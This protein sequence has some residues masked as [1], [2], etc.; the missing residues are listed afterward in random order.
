MKI[1][2][3]N[4]GS[5]SIKFKLYEKQVPVASGLV[6]KIGEHSSKIELKNLIDKKEEHRDEP[7]PNHQAG[8]KIINEFL[9]KTGIVEDLNHLDGCGHRV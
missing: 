7:V 2:V 3:I 8:V 5:S 1:L 6:G 4:S 9:H